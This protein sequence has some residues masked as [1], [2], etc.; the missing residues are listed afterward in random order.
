[1]ETKIKAKSKFKFFNQQLTTKKEILTMKRPTNKISTHKSK[2][3]AVKQNQLANSILTLCIV[4]ALV[5]TIA[6]DAHA[7][8]TAVKLDFVDNLEAT[9]K[10]LMQGAGSFVIDAMILAG[11]GYATARTSTPAPIILAILSVF[12][13][14][15]CIKLIAK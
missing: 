6:S 15:I 10:E 5:A 7:V 14:E 3:V 13:F 4:T 8:G 9:V 12:I 11:G 2:E 1:M